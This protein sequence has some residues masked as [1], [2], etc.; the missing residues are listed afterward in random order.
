[1]VDNSST[2]AIV[3]SMCQGGGFTGFRVSKQVGF[4]GRESRQ[5]AALRQL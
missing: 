2:A 1:M 5:I 4:G 3:G